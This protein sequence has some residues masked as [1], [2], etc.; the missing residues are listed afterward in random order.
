MRKVLTTYGPRRRART[1]LG[2]PLP[3]PLTGSRFR[4]VSNI[5]TDVHDVSPCPLGH[6]CESCGVESSD[7]AVTTASTPLGVLCVSLC[8]T[9]LASGIA[10][11]IA[12][13]TAVRLVAA[14]CEHLGITVDDM[15]DAIAESEAAR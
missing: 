2:T 9:C 3:G 15:A 7:L 14:H 8:P 11:P 13:G 4:P 1:V 6:R 12:I 5:S 10:P